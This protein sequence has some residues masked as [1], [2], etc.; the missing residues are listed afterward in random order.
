MGP[1]AAGSAVMTAWPPRRRRRALRD[2]GKLDRR[3]PR[4]FRHLHADD[5]LQLLHRGGDARPAG[6]DDPSRY[7]GREVDDAT[8]RR[9]SGLRCH[10]LVRAAIGCCTLA[11]DDGERRVIHH[12]RSTRAEETRMS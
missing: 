8:G 7:T 9:G 12:L 2:E 3:L 11:V 1:W 4:R 10:E 6:Y 5:G